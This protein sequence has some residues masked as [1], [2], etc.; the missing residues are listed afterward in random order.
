MS[1]YCKKCQLHIGDDNDKH[2]SHCG[3]ELVNVPTKCS[4]EYGHTF[5]ITEKYC[6]CCGKK[7]EVPSE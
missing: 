7:R 5:F 3:E 2:C 4:C 1:K 6:P